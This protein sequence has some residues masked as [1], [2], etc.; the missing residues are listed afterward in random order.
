[1]EPGLFIIF[2]MVWFGYVFFL[3][4]LVFGL[5]QNGISFALDLEPFIGMVPVHFEPVRPDK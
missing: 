5:I 3:E 1:M 4:R 2:E